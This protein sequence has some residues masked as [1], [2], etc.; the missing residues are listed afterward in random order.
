MFKALQ[1]EDWLGIAL[2]ACLLVSPWVVGFSDHSAATMN[3]LVMGS[4]LVLEEL[5]ELDVHEMAEEWIDLVAGLWLVVSP[6]A[7]GFASLTAAAASTIAVG[8][9]TMLFALW[10]MSPLDKRISHWWHDRVTGH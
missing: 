1:W 7:L 4:I 5:L 2:G 8:V 3:A 9:L 6:F 10:A